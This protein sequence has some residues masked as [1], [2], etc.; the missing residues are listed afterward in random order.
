MKENFSQSTENLILNESRVFNSAELYNI[1]TDPNFDDML[2]QATYNMNNIGGNDPILS[3]ILQEKGFDALPVMV[4]KNQFVYLIENGSTEIYR[5]V[6]R[7]N[8]TRDFATNKNLFV[9]K[10]IRCNGV[11]FMY[12]DFGNNTHH[13]DTS[14]R[15][16]AVKYVTQRL[17]ASA[18][19]GNIEGQIIGALIPKDAKVV[20]I[21]TLNKLADELKLQVEECKSLTDTEKQRLFKLLSQDVSVVA[22]LQS[23]D[24]IQVPSTK[25]MVVLNRGKLFMNQSLVEETKE[26]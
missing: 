9:G 26:I 12:G 5:G 23:F 8:A 22:A 20:D 3:R 6:G 4:S 24:A 14:A 25:Y 15:A 16:R 13:G 2:K 17:N 21:K 18:E 7:K 19:A 11:Y 10:G 1:I